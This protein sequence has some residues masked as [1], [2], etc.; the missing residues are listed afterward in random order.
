M[1][2]KK[3]LG[4]GPEPFSASEGGHGG[5]SLK[6][7]ELSEYIRLLHDYHTFGEMWVRE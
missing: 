7:T 1:I 5:T 6:T 3:P 4:W 2:E